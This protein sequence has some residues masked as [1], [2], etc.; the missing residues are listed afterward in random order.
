M[1]AHFR[2][3]G[4]RQTARTAIRALPE[5]RNNRNRSAFAIEDRTLAEALFD[6]SAEAACTN[7]LSNAVIHGLPPCIRVSLSSTVFGVIFCIAASK[8]SP[9]FFGSWF[10]TRRMLT[11]AIATA[12]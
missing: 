5:R 7:G 1:H 3:V 12:G 9:I 4:R 2:L 10:G 11:L 6:G 8:R